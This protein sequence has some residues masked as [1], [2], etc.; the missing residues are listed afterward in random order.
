MGLTIKSKKGSAFP[1]ELIV[2]FLIILIVGFI[3]LNLFRGQMMDK[4]QS[5]SDTQR[6]AI[7]EQALANA[8]T[9]CKQIC[10]EAVINKCSQR[11][12][13]EF[14]STNVGPLDLDKNGD[15][16]DFNTDLL[17]QVG[18]CEDK[19]YCPLIY[20][21][22]CANNIINFDDC[23]ENLINFWNGIGVDVNISSAGY[24]NNSLECKFNQNYDE[25]ILWSK[26]VFSSP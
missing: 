5:L 20:D 16:T 25:N 14:C 6:E 11:S 24:I 10:S 23:E 18:V 1:I 13:V 22:T 7:L 9:K 12:I 2:I 8:K 21:C 17:P 3:L 26:N 15:F 4:E 19:I